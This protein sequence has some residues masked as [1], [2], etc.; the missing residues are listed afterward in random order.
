MWKPLTAPGP[1]Y[2]LNGVY[3]NILA[4]GGTGVVDYAGSLSRTDGDVGAFERTAYWKP[5]ISFEQGRGEDMI[6]VWKLRKLRYGPGP[7]CSSRWVEKRLRKSDITTGSYQRKQGHGTEPLYVTSSGPQHAQG[8]RSDSNFRDR[9]CGLL[10]TV[11][12]RD[13]IRKVK[14]RSPDPCLLVWNEN[15]PAR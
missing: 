3:W 2:G 6:S 15:V 11:P 13:Y 12:C 1:P 10:L 14:T 8:V 7:R 5:P 9:Q 4:E